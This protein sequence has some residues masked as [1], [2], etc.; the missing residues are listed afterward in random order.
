M[1]TIGITI[2]ESVWSAGAERFYTQVLHGLEVT[3]LARGHAVLSRVAGSVEEEIDILEQWS[4]RGLVD[5]A[6]LKDLLEDDPRPGAAQRGNLPY[7]V[8]GDVRQERFASGVS[9]DNGGA[10]RRLLTELRDQGHEAI[11]H[12]GG[13][14]Q[15]LHSRWRLE[16]Y[17][18]FMRERALPV[19]TAQGDYSAASGAAS[20]RTLL[21]GN[22]R[23]TVIVYDN[24]AMA[25][26]G[27]DEAA[28]QGIDVP[29][30][31]CV[32][33]WDDSPACQMHEPPIAVVDQQPDQLGVDG[34]R[35]AIAL[36]DDPA[37]A[38]LI[39]QDIPQLIP[40]G[41]VAPAAG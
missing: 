32:V 22:T 25:I 36:I 19:L 5:V 23:P 30:G 28:A 4:Q 17:R 20:T 18:A 1:G 3:A 8:I 39:A 31:L 29:T 2:P 13:P 14:P 16:A 24:D 26:A 7:V 34:A 10:M 9:V 38:T 21:A 33:A 35:A 11:G 27:C 40:R 37:A 12:V 15:L 41:T 6:I